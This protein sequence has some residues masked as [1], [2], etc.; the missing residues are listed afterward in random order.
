M[1]RI[2]IKKAIAVFCLSVVVISMSAYQGEG[3]APQL[4]STKAISVVDGVAEFVCGTA[5]TG[6][7]VFMWAAAGCKVINDH[8]P[9]LNITAAITTGGNENIER[10]IAGEMAMGAVGTPVSYDYYHGNLEEGI[11][12][13]PDI[14]AVFGSAPN[15][16]CFM[17]RGD[18]N[19]QTIEDLKGK[20]VSINTPGSSSALTAERILT[21][22]G[23]GVDTNYYNI[24]YL[25]QSESCD[26][27]KTG[28]LDGMFIGAP[29]PHASFTDF[30][31]TAQGG[32]RFLAITDEQK[33]A[34]FNVL[35]YMDDCLVPAGAYHGQTEDYHTVG[36]YFN[37]VVMADFPEQ[38]AYEITKALDQNYNEWCEIFYGSKG[39]TSQLTIDTLVIPLHPGSERYFREIGLIK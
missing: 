28:A 22:L 18:S 37:F 5:T 39:S 2:T 30:F 12:P 15:P 3:A 33:K 32:G 9:F 17:V 16:T 1:S 19:Y 25:N 27:M 26:A 29:A 21:A 23:R 14:R 4:T 10:I 8:V 7:W 11:D 36:S 20:K 24:Q 38:L 35:P 13:H 31:L 6:G 34:I